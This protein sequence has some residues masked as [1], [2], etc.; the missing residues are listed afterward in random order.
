MEAKKRVKAEQENNKD[1]LLKMMES[2]KDQEARKKE[3]SVKFA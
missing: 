2:K 3:Y 1:Q